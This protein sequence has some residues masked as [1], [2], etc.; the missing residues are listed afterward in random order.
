MPLTTD[1][2][3]TTEADFGRSGDS[4]QHNA[5]ADLHSSSIF[6][7]LNSRLPWLLG[8]ILLIVTTGHYVTPL[9]N[10]I[11]HNILQ[12]L[13]YIPI[14]W[15][16]YR[17]G[18]RGG[19]IVSVISGAVYLPHILLGWQSHPEFQLNQIIEIVLFFAVGWCAGY[20]FEQQAHSHR[21]LQ[22]Y[23]KMALFGNLSRSIIRSLKSPIRAI[24]GMLQVL[25]PMERR[26]PALQSCVQVI[27]DEIT[28]IESVRSDLISL[29]ERKRL[30]LKKQNLNEIMFQFASHI[31]VGLKLSG[32]QLSRQAQEVKILAELN[33]G[34][35]SSVLHQLV[36]TIVERNPQAR[37]L[38][39]F[40]G[41][42][43]SFSWIGAS[44]GA[45]T[46]DSKYHGELAELSCE[47][48]HEYDLVSVLSIMNNHFGDA[49]F[50]WNEDRMV[51]FILVFPKRLKLPWYL[52]DETLPRKNSNN[53]K[54]PSATALSNKPEAA[55]GTSQ[56]RERNALK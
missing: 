35:L 2:L 48:H 6:T 39:L 33:N 3:N 16:A 27:R 23:E 30:R 4:V 18:I 43:S 8:I 22:S 34:A 14:I 55:T 45:I 20:L 29:V 9:E 51:E 1:L 21:M 7:S 15:A 46:L 38:T 37:Q 49:R 25:G 50:R 24:Q 36:G 32:L 47:Y 52:R 54:H 10:H 42:S 12:R 5:K 13:Y 40:T 31:E 56:S 11:V 19:L 26:N 53:G 44:L 17:Y 41:Q 28:R